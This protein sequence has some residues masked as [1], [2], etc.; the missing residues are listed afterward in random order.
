MP[1]KR[2]KTAQISL[3]IDANLKEAVEKAATEDHRSLTSLVE[4]L[5][6]ATFGGGAL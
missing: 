1:Q 2:K 6:T 4:Q 5:L 3:R